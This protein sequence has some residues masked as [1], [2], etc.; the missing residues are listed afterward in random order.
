[1]LLGVF[2]DPAVACN[3]YVRA[4]MAGGALS[5]S[6]LA[7]TRLHS[8][9][10]HTKINFC[11]RSTRACARAGDQ[12]QQAGAWP[13]ARARAYCASLSSTYPAHTP[14]PR[15]FSTPAR[16]ALMKR[17]TLTTTPPST[18][19][20][21]PSAQAICLS[22]H[23]HTPFSLALRRLTSHMQRPRHD[24]SCSNAHFVAS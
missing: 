22:P 9:C 23:A 3:A 10:T 24:R 11:M 8:T 21:T 4:C 14:L 13:V 5:C 16:A 19:A 17:T 15:K 6:A 1:M 7:P 18:H 2:G 12:Q 20:H